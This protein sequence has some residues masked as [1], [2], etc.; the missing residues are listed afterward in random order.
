VTTANMPRLCLLFLLS[1][2]TLVPGAAR[3]QGTA[4]SMDFDGSLRSAAMGGASNGLFRGPELNH[5]GNPALLGYVR[6]IHYEQSRTQLV[7]GLANDVWLKMKYTKIGGGGVGFVFG[8][9]PF[10]P[11]GV[12]LSYGSSEGT[13]EN[14]NPTGTFAAFERVK[15][16]GFGVNVLE[17]WE[18]VIRAAGTT[19][20]TVS[21]Y[22]DVSLGM[23]FKNAEV[24]LAPGPG[25]SGKTDA[26]DV[27]VLAR[28]TPIDRLESGTGLPVRIDLSYGWSVLSQNDDAVI[29][30]INEDMASPV[31][32]HRRHGTALQI[33]LGV[34][35]LE[36]ESLRSP[37]TR[38]FVRGLLPLLSV[39]V[40]K[41]WAELG[42]GDVVDYET[43]GNGFEVALANVFA[44][45][46]GHYED[47]IGDIDGETHG[48]S[49]GVPFGSLGGALYEEAWIPQ[50]RNSDLEDVHRTGF[51]AWIDPVA[52]WSALQS[53]SR[54]SI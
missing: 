52:I 8:G 39:S 14:G 30:F 41:D 9:Q 34:P 28:V 32:R 42:G 5:W 35:G 16:W 29:T 47:L 17:V 26:R 27:G 36:V 21:R 37:A 44:Y 40:T 51:A 38:S 6:G 7:P 20:P 13:D 11:D 43:D 31:T 54:A 12:F 46:R 18:N 3:A 53:R 19:P 22:A 33:G 50:A 2:A 15:S 45:R 49:V 10:G 23:N 4:R 48:F 25:N 24:S 1:L